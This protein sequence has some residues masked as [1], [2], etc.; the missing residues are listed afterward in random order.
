M[1]I[2]T[3]IKRMNQLYGSE[4][5]VARFGTQETYGA[6]EEIPM[7]NWRDLIREEGVQVGQQVKDGGRIYD[8]RKYFKPGGLVEPGVT[9]YGQ[10][11][12]IDTDTLIKILNES[13]DLT[14]N[15]TA[16]K[17]NKKYLTERGKTFDADNIFQRRKTLGIKT[18]IIKV[19]PPTPERT[20]AISKFLAKEVRKANQGDKFVKQTEL[21]KKA[22]IKFEMTPQKEIIDKRTGKP[23]GSIRGIG[24]GVR[25]RL[26]TN[27]YPILQTLETGAEKTDEVLKRMLISEE[28]LDNLWY[29]VVQKKTGLERKWLGELLRSGKVPTY[30]VIK[31][32]GADF[33]SNNFS[34]HKDLLKNLSFSDQLSKAV[35]MKEGRPVLFIGGEFSRGYNRPKFNVLRY[36]FQ[37]W[38]QN[39]G[40]G[41]IKFFDKPVGGEKITWDYGNEVNKRLKNSSFSYKG[42]RYNLTNLEDTDI[43]KKAFPEVYERTLQATSFGEKKI[44]N[45][46][47]PGSKIQVKDLIKKIQVDGYK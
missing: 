3:Y 24:E 10:K 17:L 9:H 4:Q 38:D 25:Y 7:P 41:D 15:Q 28:P 8:T 32:Q 47:K 16:D 13:K 42:K 36:A 26:D 40:Q 44:E 21:M 5:Q 31:D 18:D 14:D 2:L 12:R 43:L 37:S 34:T 35:R 46:F 22:I 19:N 30:N 6:P 29:R 45:P 33:I 20:E 11:P 39:R 1:D 27:A 23:K